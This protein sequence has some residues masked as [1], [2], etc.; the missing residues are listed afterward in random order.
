[1]YVIQNYFYSYNANNKCDRVNP[2]TLLTIDI[3]KGLSRISTCHRGG[4]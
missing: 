3:K 2:R 4:I 1:M